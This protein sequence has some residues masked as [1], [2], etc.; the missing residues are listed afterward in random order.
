MVALWVPKPLVTAL[1]KGVRKMDSDRSK[2]IRAALREKLQ[3]EQI[4]P[5]PTLP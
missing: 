1:D 4:D 2:F 3:R 5:E